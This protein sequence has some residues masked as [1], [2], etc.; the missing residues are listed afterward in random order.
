MSAQSGVVTI[1]IDADI[2]S[3]A[4]DVGTRDLICQM[5]FSP[6]IIRNSGFLHIAN[7]SQALHAQTRH[8]NLDL[9]RIIPPVRLRIINNS[10]TMHDARAEPKQKSKLVHLAICAHSKTKHNHG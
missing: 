3:C 9:Y 1:C 4:V 10:Q 7:V 2:G 5:P 8:Q 6:L